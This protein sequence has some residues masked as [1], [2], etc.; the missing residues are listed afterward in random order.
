MRRYVS[1]AALGAVLALA[2]P[3]PAAHACMRPIPLIDVDRDRVVAGTAVHVTGD[4]TSRADGTV[5]PCHPP[6]PPSPV[7]SVT[8]S[9]PDGVV[10]S[11]E[12]E[13]SGTSTPLVTIP[14]VR[15]PELRPVAYTPPLPPP[16][17]T[18]SIRAWTPEFAAE[19]PLRTLATV[20]QAPRAH[21]QDD[22]YRFRFAADVTI[23]RDLRPGR[24]VLQATTDS[25]PF[26][27]TAD[28]TV[29]DEL[30]A[31]GADSVDLTG[32]AVLSIV[33]GGLVLELG[34]RT[35]HAAR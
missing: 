2:L 6:V 28:V 29:L 11:P 14:P 16:T 26:F 10:V 17:V 21:V 27:G 31:T 7:P 1:T 13:P 3:V 30:A 25:G 22:L 19:A 15:A 12:P 20:P 24:W 8:P 35:R 9:D 34:R 4:Q 5:P 23:P 18:V 32:I 33:A